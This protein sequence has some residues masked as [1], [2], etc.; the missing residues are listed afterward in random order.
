MEDVARL[1]I[2]YREVLQRRLPVAATIGGLVLAITVLLAVLLPSYYKSRAVILIEAQEMPQDLVRSM[3]TSYADQRVQI[4]S[5][6]V[7]TNSNLTA[8]VEKYRLYEEERRR[9]PL[10]TILEQMRKS[11]VIT[12]VSAD[13]VDP[14]GGRAVQATIAFELSY[15]NK[16]PILAQRVANEVSSLFLSENLR[17]RKETSEESL[18]FMTEE[19]ERRRKEVASFES[20]LAAFK[21]GN[22]ERLPE[23]GNLNI[24]LTNRTEN[25][26]RSLD[27]QIQSLQQQR[28]YLESELAQQNPSLGTFSETGERI[29]GP[30]DRLKVLKA[31][32][33]PLSARYGP[34]H[35]DVIAKRKEIEA[36]TAEVG[37]AGETDEAA[38][39]LRDSL[40][41]LASMR[42]K[43]SDD[44][45][46]VKKLKAE[47]QALEMQ[48]A[49]SPVS[50]ATRNVGEKADN[51]AYIQLRARLD[52]VNNDIKGL[53]AQRESLKRKLNELNERI[54]SSPDV[55]R[56]YREL[57]R[58]YE[59]A[60][61]KYREIMAK[62]QEAELASNLESEQR[63]ER[64]TLIE[65]PV[66]PEEPA[67]PNRAAIAALGVMLSLL[68]GFGGGMAAES[69]DDRIYGRNGVIRVLG[70]A[71]LAVIPSVN[72]P[73]SVRTRRLKLTTW[74]G[75]A[76]LLVLGALMAIHFSYRPLDVLFFRLLRFIGLE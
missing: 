32:F 56:Q 16:S 49:E 71:P 9:R 57:S 73:S 3:V 4:I 1:E 66:T 26:I 24:E 6:R 37:D 10:E 28:V 27:S 70:I 61:L 47:V 21:Q 38:L 15:E 48:L 41:R 76:L 35:P 75:G 12:P 45:P 52:S 55:E 58:D 39:K 50:M 42:K 14:K 5:Q 69:L 17:Q 20:K 60:Q 33:A 43:Y 54:A 65:P 63:G 34:S 30:T 18:K 67:K 44:Y 40:G 23:F 59:S 62:R 11:I 64:F 36:L 51:P 31:E 29:L 19:Y 13:V 25:D 22:V 46:D 7:L 74:V 2:D 8:I 72:N 68:A 53:G